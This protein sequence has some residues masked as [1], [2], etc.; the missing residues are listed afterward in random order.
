MI[1][2]NKVTKKYTVDSDTIYALDDVSLNIEEGSIYG[3]IGLSGAGKSTLLRCLSTLEKPDS[4]EIIINNKNIYKL[5]GTDLRNFRS[6]IG[7]VFQGYNLLMQRTA[8]DNVAFPLRIRKEKKLKVID[9]VDELFK[10]VGLEGK[11]KSYPSKL[12]GGQKQRVAIAR[13]LA[14]NP[15]LVLFD[16]P[17]SALDPITTKQILSLIKEINNKYQ[18]TMIIITHEMSL[19]KNVCDRVAVLNYGK[20]VEEGRVNEVLGNPQNEITRM[21]LG[22]ELII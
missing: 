21:L 18:V 17:T 15:S 4:G 5:S 13:A 9:R 10:F 8:F 7:V 6:D 22:K 12:S 20:V 1:K 19:V 3:I 2:I 14:T 11:E 16:E